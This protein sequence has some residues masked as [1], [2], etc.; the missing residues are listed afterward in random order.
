[1]GGALPLVG[2]GTSPYS[3]AWSNG[4]STFATTSSVYGLTPGTYTVTV[5]DANGCTATASTTINAL[6]SISCS[7]TGTNPLC[8]NTNTGTATVT[9]ANGSGIV[10]YLWNSTPA[11]TTAT[12]TGLP[13]GVYEVKV[14]D[15]VGCSSNCS[16]TLV[17]PAPINAYSKHS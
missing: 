6:V 7:A 3:Y 12:A 8:F 11:Q 2:G 9:T 15:A 13:V 4:T 1:M 10:T 14:M 5:T 16:V 17:G